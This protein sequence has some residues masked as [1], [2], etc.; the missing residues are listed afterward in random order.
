MPKKEKVKVDLITKE[1]YE[2]LN[3]ILNKIRVQLNSNISIR[4]T[5]EGLIIIQTYND[6][7]I[8]RSE[9]KTK[10]IKTGVNFLYN[11][12]Y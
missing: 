9:V 3:I 12:I 2:T 11:K 7:G 5:L 4:D 8:I 10:S 1:E 6:S